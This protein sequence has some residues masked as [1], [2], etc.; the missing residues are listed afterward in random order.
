VL[1]QNLVE[2]ILQKVNRFLQREAIQVVKNQLY[3]EAQSPKAPVY[4]QNLALKVAVLEVLHQ[5]AAHQKVAQQEAVPLVNLKVVAIE[6]PEED[7]E[8]I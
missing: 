4:N 2:V 6:A 1:L 3:L 5:E 7:K 8:N